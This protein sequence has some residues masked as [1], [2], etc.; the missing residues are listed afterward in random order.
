VGWPCFALRSHLGDV[1]KCVINAVQM[2]VLEWSVVGRKQPFL[3]VLFEWTLKCRCLDSYATS[4][5][6]PIHPQGVLV[7]IVTDRTCKS[8]DLVQWSIVIEDL[9]RLLRIIIRPKSQKGTVKD[10]HDC[11]VSHY[12]RPVP[13]YLHSIVWN[14]S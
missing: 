2:G 8:L 1:M 12:R 7:S 10:N 14:L 13:E 11:R 6:I 5:P 3:H 4:H 9:F